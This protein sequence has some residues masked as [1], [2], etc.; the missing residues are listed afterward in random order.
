[1]SK[2]FIVFFSVLF[3]NLTANSQI[4][5]SLKTANKHHVGLHLSSL[6]GLGFS[7]RY[8]PERLGGQITVMQVF[9]KSGGHFIS[10]GATGLYTLKK[11]K[12]VDLYSYLGTHY[13]S[14]KFSSNQNGISSFNSG[15]GIGF[16]INLSDFLNLNIQ[17]GYGVYTA[18][19]TTVGTIAGGL[20]LYYSF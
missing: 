6:S 4:Q 3:F 12:T 16:K 9:N 1:M 15:L 8:W 7:Y 10:L 11:G 2:L 14:I 20:G 18:N 17:S 19:E 13:L 5:D